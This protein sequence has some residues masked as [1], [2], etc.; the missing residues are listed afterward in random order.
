[1]VGVVQ[2]SPLPKESICNCFGCVYVYPGQV[3]PGGSYL[4]TLP[5]DTKEDS[6][7][8]EG[9]RERGREGGRKG[10]SGKTKGGRKGR[11]ERERG[12]QERRS[13]ERE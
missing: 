1:M 9:G 3:G 12:K 10:R 5:E 2:S 4:S 13:G 6:R 7:E 11:V 8:R